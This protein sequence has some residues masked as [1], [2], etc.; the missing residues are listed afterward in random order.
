MIYGAQYEKHV[1]LKD[2]LQKTPE[3][4]PGLQYYDMTREEQIERSMKVIKKIITDPNLRRLHKSPSLTTLLGDYVQGQVKICSLN[5]I[6]PFRNQSIY[7]FDDDS[8]FRYGRT[9]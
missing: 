2:L 6:D 3:L 8:K 4:Q 7:V 5:V 9:S 1:E